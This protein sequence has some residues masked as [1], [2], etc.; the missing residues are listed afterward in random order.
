MTEQ[1]IFMNLMEIFISVSVKSDRNI[2]YR[3]LGKM[4]V[5]LKWPLYLK[6]VLYTIELLIIIIEIASEAWFLSTGAWSNR[7]YFTS[8]TLAEDGGNLHFGM[9]PK[10]LVPWKEKTITAD[11]RN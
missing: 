9:F 7:M 8:S 1:L 5:T 2:S 3:G 4:D 10:L 6:K 11:K